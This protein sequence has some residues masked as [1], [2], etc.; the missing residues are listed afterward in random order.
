MTVS[1]AEITTL[2]CIFSYFAGFI[3]KSELYGISC[4]KE[5]YQSLMCRAHRYLFLSKN[6]NCTDKIPEDLT[7][8]IKDFIDLQSRTDF[9]ETMSTSCEDNNVQCTL[10][11]NIASS[12]SCSGELNINILL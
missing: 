5:H 9:Y 7:C 1:A 2:K 4:N 8:E 10:N 11:H 12:S 6:T 3:A